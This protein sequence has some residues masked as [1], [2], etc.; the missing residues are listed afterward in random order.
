MSIGI[1]LRDESDSM[2]H[3]TVQFFYGIGNYFHLGKVYEIRT[4]E[5]RIA[6]REYEF[7]FDFIDNRYS[8][9]QRMSG[10]LAPTS[11]VGVWEVTRTLIG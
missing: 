7:H 6:Y 9:T 1:N 2:G 11:I 10:S 8:L 3:A 4:G 5:P